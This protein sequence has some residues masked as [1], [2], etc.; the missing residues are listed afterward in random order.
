MKVISRNSRARWVGITLLA[1]PWCSALQA[2][3]TTPPTTG[4]EADQPAQNPKTGKSVTSLKAVTVTADRRQTNLQT[5]PIA[6][7]VLSGDDL[8][9]LGVNVVD[10]LQFTTPSTT[11]NNFGQGI[12]FDIRGIGK[13]EHNTQTSTGVITYRDGVATF[14]GYFAEEPYYDIASVQILRGPQ[15]TFGGQNAIGGAV[16]VDSN[17][18]VINAGYHGYVQAQGG[19]YSDVG[20]QGA[21]NLP[22]SSTLAARVA[23]DSDNRDSFWN[24][25]G[26]YTG[27]NA[28]QRDRSA[29]I[30]LLWQPSD[31]FSVLLKTDL[32]HLDM[33]AYPADPVN[34]PNNPFDITANANLMAL[35]RFSRTT[36]KIDYKFPNGVQLR[37]TS[38]Y[39]TGTT[40]YQADLDGTALGNETFRD[41][42][43]ET[44]YSQELNLISPDTG[45]LTW[46]LGAYWQRDTYT[47]PVGQYL[48]GVPP[49]DP[50]TEYTLS[51]TNPQETKALFGQVAYQLSDGLKLDVEGR[52]SKSTTANNVFVVQYGLP[53]EDQQSASY[54][55][56]S[57]KVAIDWTLNDKQFL[58]AFAATGYRPGGLNVPVGLGLPAPF[59]Q[60]KVTSLEAG[61]KASWLDNHLRTQIDAFHNNYDNFQ[62]TIGYPTYPTFG[63]ELNTPNPTEIYGVEAQVQ[64]VFGDWSLNTNVG[65][66]HSELGRF[67]ATDPRLPSV[68][69]CDPASGPA[70]AGCVDLDGREQTYAPNLTFNVALE[71]AFHFGS[72]TVT[73]RINY[74]HISSQWATLFENQALGDRLGSRNLLGA[75]VDWSHGDFLWTLYGS[76]L[77]NQ[78]YIAAINSNLRFAGAPRQ[79][80]IRVTKFF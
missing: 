7:T 61:W 21:I 74:A 73:P 48:I 43:D 17:D 57:G 80:G 37:A 35:D 70:G 51:G 42:V 10:Q 14:P 63:I 52:Y 50:A 23:V 66:M 67:Y 5:T 49:G 64:A 53:L 16:L 38:G 58:Y 75:Q 41:S 40:S 39:Q 13:A 71:R 33:G 8:N 4:T 11:V 6:A 62:V 54:T 9:K 25:T 30:G 69:P 2:Q 56:F 29:R 3:N 18:P 77:T 31:D 68:A 24:I 15:G 1:L 27:S 34:S 22:I 20:L 59:K 65:W 46:V 72:D 76:N 36:L 19:N 28:R 26:P 12:D 78:Q 32:N 45:P 47:F 44:I 60:E 79:F 55:S